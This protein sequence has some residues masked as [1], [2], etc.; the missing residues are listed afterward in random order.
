MTSVQEMK[1]HLSMYVKNDMSGG[2]NLPPKT[3]KRYYPRIR[4]IRNHKCFERQE[5]KK[6]LIDQEA[7]LEKVDE[8]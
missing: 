4:V 6:S 5:W 2:I 8:W 7:L 3:N 1:R